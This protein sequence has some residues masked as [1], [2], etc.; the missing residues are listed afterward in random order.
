[1]DNIQNTKVIENAK[2]D[3][4]FHRSQA[5]N[6]LLSSFEKKNEGIQ[7]LFDF[8]DLMFKNKMLVN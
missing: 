6:V 2:K 7:I 1:M 8:F 5:E 3:I 4:G